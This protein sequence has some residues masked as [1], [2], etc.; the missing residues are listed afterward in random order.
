MKDE[1]GVLLADSHNI[2]NKWMNY[3]SVTDC[4]CDQ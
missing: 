4:A 1:N 3:F 2:F